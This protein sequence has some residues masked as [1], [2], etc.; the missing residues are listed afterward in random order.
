MTGV[1]S[2]QRTPTAKTAQELSDAS[3]MVH[4][5]YDMMR[6][7]ASVMMTGGGGMF[8]SLLKG[9]PPWQLEAAIFNNTHVESF[10]V[11]VR[12]LMAFFAWIP[13]R[14]PDDVCACDFDASWSPQVPSSAWFLEVTT[15][16]NKNIQ[17][18]T[19]SRTKRRLYD[20]GWDFHDIASKL[21]AEMDR[22]RKL[23]GPKLLQSLTWDTSPIT[24][25]AASSSR[26]ATGPAAPMPA[27][28]LHATQPKRS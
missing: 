13:C 2:S 22:F 19:Y 5:E 20:W 6:K 8:Y 21:D 23:A 10:V 17:H 16:I 11:H 26:G 1:G 9:P 15:A 4:Y 7:I 12:N 27:D 24:A 18:L 25:P 28:S 3:E 14:D